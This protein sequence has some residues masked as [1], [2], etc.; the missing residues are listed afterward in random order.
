MCNTLDKACIIAFNYKYTVTLTVRLRERVLYD[1][2]LLCFLLGYSYRE[3][4]RKEN[5]IIFMRTL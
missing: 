4:N 1:S 3:S 2:S 5:E